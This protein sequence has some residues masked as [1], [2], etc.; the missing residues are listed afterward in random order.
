MP[1]VKEEWKWEV[2][3][4]IMDAQNNKVQSMIHRKDGEKAS[5]PGFHGQVVWQKRSAERERPF[6]CLERGER[7]ETER[8]VAQEEG[9]TKVKEVPD[10]HSTAVSDTY[11][12]GGLKQ[13]TS[14][15]GHRSRTFWQAPR[16]MHR[17]AK[18][19]SNRTVK[20]TM[21]WGPSRTGE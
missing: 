7:K 2:V 11:Q 15:P 6:R 21:C 17:P 10:S 12:S 19:T 4:E 13:T 18:Y 14:R 1:V 20:T 3:R 5:E 8:T 16:R 9:I